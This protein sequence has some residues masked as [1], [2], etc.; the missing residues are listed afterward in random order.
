MKGDTMKK[1]LALS[2]SVAFLFASSVAYAQSVS[3][4]PGSTAVTQ[5]ATL[6]DAAQI[7]AHSHTPAATLT[8]TSAPGMYVYV[9]GMDISNCETGTAVTA[10]SPAYI[11]TTG[12]NGSPQYQVGTGPAA[13]GTCSPTQNFAFVKALKAGQQGTNVTFVLPVNVANRILSVNVYYFVAP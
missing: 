8:L 3:V 11:T 5:T 13:A 12:L 10:A 4:P 7:V 2:L 6:N 1:M 9:T